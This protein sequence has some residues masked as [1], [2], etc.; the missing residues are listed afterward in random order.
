[1]EVIKTCQDIWTESHKAQVLATTF[2]AHKCYNYGKENNLQKIL[3]I[4]VKLD[5]ENQNKNV[6][7]VQKI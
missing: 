2:Q 7:C 1:M 6:Q 3:E 4:I 5:K